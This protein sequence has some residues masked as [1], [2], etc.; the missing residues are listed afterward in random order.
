MYVHERSMNV[1]L[2]KDKMYVTYMQL[3]DH[4]ASYFFM[5]NECLDYISVQKK[6]GIQEYNYYFLL[7]LL[8][9]DIKS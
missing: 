5:Q 6:K 2:C 3:V 9:C 1:K 7:V 8:F 4:F